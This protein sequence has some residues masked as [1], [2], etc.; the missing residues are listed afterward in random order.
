MTY[1]EAM[2]GHMTKNKD[3]VVDMKAM[4]TMCHKKPSKVF[5]IN[6]DG[7]FRGCHLL[8]TTPLSSAGVELRRLSQ[9]FHS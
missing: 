2:Y 1:H 8:P 4:G 5:G 9:R 6:S 3:G 7:R